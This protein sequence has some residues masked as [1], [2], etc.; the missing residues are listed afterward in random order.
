MT[1]PVATARGAATGLTVLVVGLLVLANLAQHVLGWSTLWL[2]PLTA[3]LLLAVA[4]AAGLGWAELG[5]ARSRLRAGARW[6]GSA[7]LLVAAAYAVGLV[8]P[9]TRTAFLDERYHLGAGEVAL[10]AFVLIPLAT[11][12]PEEIAFRSVL[13][14]VLARRSGP[15]GVLVGQAVLF[16]LW[17]VLVALEVTGTNRAVDDAVDGGVGVWLVVAGTVLLTTAGGLVFGELRRRSDSVLAP[18]GMHWA[19]NSLGVLA[20]LAAWRLAG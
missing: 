10:A 7:I 15:A 14:G 6:G 20:G 2:G 18:M 8:L 3:V 9:V 11:V 16:G 19:T 17:H 4:R 13:W 12:V 1:A 5:L